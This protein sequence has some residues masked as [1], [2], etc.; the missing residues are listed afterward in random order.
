MTNKKLINRWK[1]SVQNNYGT[2]TIALVKG[3]GIVVTDA[4]G[5]KYLDFLGGIATNIL[6]HAHPSVI[7][8]VTRQISVLSHVSNF[9]AH[10]NAVELAEKLSSMT[11]DKGAKVFF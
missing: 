2:P 11:G 10:P 1:T 8:A 7:K 6:G 9:Y 4:D 5:K 3:T